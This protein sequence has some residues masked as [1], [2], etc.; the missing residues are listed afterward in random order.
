[1]VVCALGNPFKKSAVIKIQLRFD[2]KDMND[3]EN[4]LEFIVFSNTTSTEI[5]PQSPV[6]LSANV[7]E[8][9]ELKLLGYKL[10]IQITILQFLISTTKCTLFFCYLGW[11]VQ[12]KCFMAVK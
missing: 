6:I 7:I 8:Q 3:S 2:P 12:N 11:H 9:A 10:K 5:E 1:M 4:Q